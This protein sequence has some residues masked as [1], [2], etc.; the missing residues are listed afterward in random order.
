MLELPSHKLTFAGFRLRLIDLKPGAQE[1][2]E[3]T[4]YA[5]DSVLK[6][7]KLEYIKIRVKIPNHVSQARL[8][9]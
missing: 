9:G 2:T 3:S 4:R 6:S 1:L 5:S 8:T 7:T